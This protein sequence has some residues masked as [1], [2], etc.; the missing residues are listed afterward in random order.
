MGGRGSKRLKPPVNF[1]RVLGGWR[2]ALVLVGVMSREHIPW[3][4]CPKTLQYLAIRRPVPPH[5]ASKQ[6]PT[7]DHLRNACRSNTNCLLFIAHP[8]LALPS[9]VGVTPPPPPLVLFSASSPFFPKYTDKKR[10]WTTLRSS[11]SFSLSWP[12]L[13]RST[14][15]A[16]TWTRRTAT[17]STLRTLLLCRTCT[18]PAPGSR[19]S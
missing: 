14:S 13:T 2:G 4:S 1:R 3:Q 11:V 16:R 10:C 19:R 8:A 15:P 12:W 6:P 5:K 9:G 7:H 18:P 17:T